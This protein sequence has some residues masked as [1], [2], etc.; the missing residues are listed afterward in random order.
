M[1][2]N[3]DSHSLSLSEAQTLRDQA[4]DLL[5]R[6]LSNR[7]MSEKRLAES[8]KRDPMKFITGRT[9][10]DDAIASTRE[11]IGQ[12]EELMARLRAEPAAADAP[13]PAA[14]PRSRPPAKP[15]FRGQF[16]PAAAT[17]ST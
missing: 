5:N 13:T 8:G 9:S 3:F 17:I 16:K 4:S 7:E 14:R 10:L 12:M 6:L 11:M 2:K 1:V 15:A